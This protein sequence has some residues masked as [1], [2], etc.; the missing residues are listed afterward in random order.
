[1]VVGIVTASH[2]VNGGSCHTC[3]NDPRPRRLTPVPQMRRL[4]TIGPRWVPS[5]C[6][7]GC[8]NEQ[9]NFKRQ[10]LMILRL[11]S[12]NRF[13]FVVFSSIDEKNNEIWI[14]VLSNTSN[15]RLF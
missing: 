4:F 14:V 12:L 6:V 9:D 5:I 15:F 11:S 10:W 13:F 1:M 2:V 7:Y 3:L 8:F